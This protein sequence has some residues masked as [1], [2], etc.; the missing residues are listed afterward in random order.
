MP[1]STSSSEP[2]DDVYDRPLP[3]LRFG[4]AAIVALAVFATGFVGW[5]LY[6]RS[7]GAE[8]SFANSDGLWAIQRRRID[9][10]EGHR[11]VIIGDSRLL[12]DIDLDTWERVAGQR[13]IQLALE[14]TSAMFALEDLAD[15]PDFTGQLIVGVAPELFFSGFAN[16]GSVL[17]YYKDETP[18]QRI[19][20][21][22]SMRLIEPWFAYYD[23]DFALFTVL[24]RQAW[25]AR[26]GVPSRMRVR[27]LASFDTDRNTKLWSKV[28][29]DAEY[30]ALAKRIWAQGSEPPDAKKRAEMDKAAEKQ[31]AKA[32]AAVGK[33]RA[34]GVSVVFIR[35]PSSGDFL[36]WENRDLPR[37][38]TWDVLLARTGAP[39]IHFEDHPEL[40][41]FEL[42]EWSHLAAADKPRFT[43][44]LV[45]VILR[46]PK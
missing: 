24:K 45:R 38:N 28:E 13:P 20:Q 43:E 4:I 1:S 14:G 26:E 10:G 37:A 16:R 36:M 18:S 32:V 44:A 40:Q 35:P 30:R 17:A 25:P 6:W 2:I 29:T 3:R 12:F 46:L 19:T 11:P 39:G 15:D 9:E 8:P 34:R 21:W 5:E 22:L 23:E 41:G 31:I 42:P 7:Y 27:K 33:L